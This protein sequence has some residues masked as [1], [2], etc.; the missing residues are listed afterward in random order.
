ME[1]EMKKGKKGM[2][3]A[4]VVISL[5]GLAVIAASSTILAS[6]APGTPLAPG[7]HLNLLV[8]NT[9]IL[10]AV[11]VYSGLLVWGLY[12]TLSGRENMLYDLVS[13]S[14]AYA[15]FLYFLTYGR[16]VVWVA[17]GLFSVL[18]LLAAVAVRVRRI[19]V[20]KRGGKL[21]GG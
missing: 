10:V 1:K 3:V 14:A 6:A 11:V 18:V 17:R 16:Y 7:T 15:V 5:L 13:L 2:P 9:S 12:L 19:R 8:Y 4:F 20:K 21:T